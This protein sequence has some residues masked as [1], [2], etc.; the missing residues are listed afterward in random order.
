[1]GDAA[2]R[3]G[4]WDRLTIRVLP[5]LAFIVELLRPFNAR[6]SPADPTGAQLQCQKNSRD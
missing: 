2:R 6:L 1:M 4:S 5:R 3:D